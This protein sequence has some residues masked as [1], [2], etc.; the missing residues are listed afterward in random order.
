LRL[1]T[2]LVDTQYVPDLRL[3]LLARIEIERPD[4]AR[5]LAPWKEQLEQQKTM[6]RQQEQQLLKSY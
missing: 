1:S 6:I 5:Q 4:V 3:N 2:F